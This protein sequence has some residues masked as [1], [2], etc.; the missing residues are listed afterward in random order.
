[1]RGAVERRLP[2][3]AIVIAISALVFAI[4]GT[5]AAVVGLTKKEKGQVKN[6]ANAQIN[7]AAPNLTVK[8]AS[9]AGSA[10]SANRAN[11][12]GSADSIGGLEVRKFFAKVPNGTGETNLINTGLITLTGNCT[13]GD[14][15]L[16][17][18]ENSG[19]DTALSFTSTNTAGGA[20]LAN[21]SGS[22]NNFVFNASAA[23]SSVGEIVVSSSGGAVNSITFMTRDPVI[24]AGNEDACLF[25]GN[26]LSG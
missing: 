3:A 13:G 20:I 6:L 26:V 18:T 10:T 2:S 4:G 1:M 24:F 22:F 7:A 25:A 23:V 12:A 21:G 17:G 9:T 11:T 16:K 19:Q 14:S 8:S 15:V 5:A